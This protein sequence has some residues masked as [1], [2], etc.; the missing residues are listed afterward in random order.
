MI[1]IYFLRISIWS[2]LYKNKQRSL[3]YM[4]ITIISWKVFTWH[5]L[6]LS[7]HSSQFESRFSV[8]GNSLQTQTA[9]CIAEAQFFCRSLTSV[10]FPPLFRQSLFSRARQKRHL[11]I[12]GDVSEADWPLSIQ[13]DLLI[14]GF[15][16][17]CCLNALGSSTSLFSTSSTNIHWGMLTVHES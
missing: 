8:L 1:I 12:A 17:T 7:L 6:F 10:W 3:K 9:Q 5:N 15:A 4:K 16:C 13:N 11:I 2:V 14:V